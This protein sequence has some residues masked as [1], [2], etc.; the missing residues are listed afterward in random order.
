MGKCKGSNFKNKLMDDILKI[1]EQT[2]KNLE[3]LLEKNNQILNILAKD[4]PQKAD[5]IMRDVN[6]T[7]SALKNNDSQKINDL[8]EKYANYTNQ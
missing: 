2:T 4:E 8:M 7:M 5:E 3:L 1:V 6:E